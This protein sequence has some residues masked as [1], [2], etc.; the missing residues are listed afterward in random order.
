MA[1]K[2]TSSGA[3]WCKHPV[4]VQLSLGTAPDN[5]HLKNPCR[6]LPSLEPLWTR[7]ASLPHHQPTRQAVANHTQP[8]IYKHQT[9]TDSVIQRVSKK[10]YQVDV[11]GN[12]NWLPLPTSTRKS[13]EIWRQNPSRINRKSCCQQRLRDCICFLAM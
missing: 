11:R 3:L 1:G 13:I 6:Q 2:E 8:D 4:A 9:I 12:R 7:Q 10:Y 5:Y